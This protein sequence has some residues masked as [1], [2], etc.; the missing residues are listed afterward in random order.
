[1]ATFQTAL[2]LH[3]AAH[4]PRRGGSRG[5][6]RAQRERLILDVADQ[7]FARDGYHSASMDEIARRSG[8]SKPMLYSYFGSKE[9]LYVACIDRNGQE[10]VAR[11][12][13]AFDPAA[14]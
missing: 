4:S 9:G 8:V 11:L 12:Q 13:Q 6:P 1:M 3:T 10:L 2:P 7:V 5:M 14:S